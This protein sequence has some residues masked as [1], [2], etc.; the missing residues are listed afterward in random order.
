MSGGTCCRAAQKRSRGEKV[1]R[2]T[3]RT[4]SCWLG[5]HI[6]SC[7]WLKFR[8][9][10][11]LKCR[12][13][14]AS[15]SGNLCH[16]SRT[17]DWGVASPL[18]TPEIKRKLGVNKERQ[19]DTF[20]IS[21]RDF[22]TQFQAINICYLQQWQELRLKG[23]FIRVQDVDDPNVEAVL[24]RWYY[25]IAVAERTQIVI[26]LHQ[27]D[28]RVGGR[29][30]LDAGIAVLRKS[31]DS[32]A[33]VEAKDF[34]RRRECEVEVVLDAGDYIVLPRTTGCTLKRLA[35]SLGKNAKFLRENGE[36]DW[37]LELV[38]KEIFRKFDI[39]MKQELTYSEF[40]WI[41]ESLNQKISE[42][43]FYK[44]FLP[45]YCSHSKGLCFRG[46]KE[47]F[48]K[49]LK[50]LDE[51][52]IWDWLENLGYNKSL[53]PVRS[54]TF[55]LTLHSDKE[56]S[57]N[58]RDA[59]ATSLDNTTSALIV[60]RYGQEAEKQFGIKLLYIFSQYLS[61]YH[62]QVQSYAYGVLNETGKTV[63]AILDCSMSKHMTYSA[64]SPIVKKRVEPEQTEFML[65]AQ[66]IPGNEEFVNEFKFTW[67]EIAE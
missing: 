36:M 40:K 7:D 61:Y 64:R 20:W 56:L 48:L 12:I 53:F 25:N 45:K 16:H 63:E 8:G 43:E 32:V 4:M 57:V 6:Q 59:I 24:S 30:Y 21:F 58:V 37:R 54:R 3:R 47:F 15:L 11:S 31:G 28:E 19:D 50:E 42:E 66:A 35:D 1:P 38:L 39:Q 22:L 9:T 23:R 18:W 10:S 51:T 67:K 14:G 44:T 29:C 60:E 17:G 55:I 62:R 49:S 27:E 65:H 41:C 5:I 2:A 52:I 33:L 34:V 46:F 13:Y 26:T